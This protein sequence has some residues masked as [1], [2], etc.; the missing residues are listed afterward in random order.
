[1]NIKEMIVILLTSLSV[2]VGQQLGFET[3]SFWIGI[4]IAFF[5]GVLTFILLSK[6]I[7]EKK[8]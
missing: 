5:L 3:I 1:M 2:L 6:E 8:K 4:L 7:W